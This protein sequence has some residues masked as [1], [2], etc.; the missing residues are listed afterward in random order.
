MTYSLEIFPKHH[1]FLMFGDIF[2]AINEADFKYS[3]LLIKGLKYTK[4]NSIK[5]CTTPLQKAKLA[6]TFEITFQILPLIFIPTKP[7]LRLKY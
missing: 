5:N 1:F 6:H 7:I 2:L 3:L 4:I